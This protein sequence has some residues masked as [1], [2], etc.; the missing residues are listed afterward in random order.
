MLD[1]SRHV[2]IKAEEAQII[3][4][5]PKAEANPVLKIEPTVVVRV[6]ECQPEWC[7][8]QVSGRK[9]WLEKRFLWG[10]Y[11]EEVFD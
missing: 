2:M 7:R 9:G 4:I 3:R 8:I 6:I 1:G 10:V 5:D 11:K